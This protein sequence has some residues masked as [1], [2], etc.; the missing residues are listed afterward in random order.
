MP[1]AV[2]GSSH[3]AKR[4]PLSRILDIFRGRV[5]WIQNA[6]WCAQDLLEIIA[7]PLREPTVEQ[8]QFVQSERPSLGN[9]LEIRSHLIEGGH[10][11]LGPFFSKEEAER[12]ERRFRA[13][14]MPYRL[15]RSPLWRPLGFDPKR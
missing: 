13:Y 1:Y 11:G 2:I 4:F 6:G 14:K 9:Y 8:I 10:F 15:A 12:S 3:E 7:E 5:R